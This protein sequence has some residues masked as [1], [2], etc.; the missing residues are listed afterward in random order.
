MTGLQATMQVAYAL[1]NAGL[2]N[3]KLL[4][5]YDAR[6]ETGD[7]PDERHKAHV[8]LSASL[9]QAGSI[10]T[11]MLSKLA[12]DAA[13][14]DKD[15]LEQSGLTQEQANDVLAMFHGIIESTSAVS[16]SVH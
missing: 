9:C 5:D 12:A 4:E 10:L 15:A 8:V 14:G 7:I 2:A 6:R 13:R 16:G 3:A 11:A 1:S